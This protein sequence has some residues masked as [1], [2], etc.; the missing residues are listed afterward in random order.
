[1]KKC[2][3]VLISVFIGW[4]FLAFINDDKPKPE[5][6]PENVQR[7]G[8]AKKGY[9]YLI[10][11][12]YIKSGLP[13]SFFK[14]GLGRNKNNFLKR[15]GINKDISHE[16]TAIKAPNGQMVV[17]PNCL[18]CHAQVFDGELIIGM[19]N[20]AVDFTEQKSIPRRMKNLYRFLSLTTPKKFAASKEFLLSTQTLAPNLVTDVRGVNAAGRLAALLVAHRNPITL[21]WSTE[22][23]MDVPKEVVPTDVPAWWLLKKKNAM[24]Y[25][26][27]GRGDFPKFLM[28]SNLL[29]VKDTVEANEVYSHF[30]DV[31]AYIYSITPPKYPKQINKMLAA[32]G[33]QIFGDNCAKCHGTY[34]EDESYPNLLI[35][36]G[37]IQTDS[38]LFKSNYTAPQFIS[39]FNNSWFTTGS[40][41][42]MLVP[43]SGYIAPPLDGIWA[44]APYL[45][46]GSVP[47]LEGV[48]SSK[49]RPTFWSRNFEKPEYNYDNPGWKVTVYENK[50]HG[51]VYN[52]NKEGYGNYGHY[53]G[54]K[55]SKTERSAVI[56]YLKT[57]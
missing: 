31:L 10:T 35:P 27:F 15:D 12:D 49:E 8:D 52:T 4:I 17:T 28:A 11:G 19:G 18:Q 22:P 40:N 57:L 41:P 13:Y 14:M 9:D 39:W 34:G 25:N 32:N 33:K 45:H 24:F 53:F 37:I 48:L 20:T 6:I 2:V 26:G 47:N 55:L 36:A 43:Y 16:F 51:N 21:Q 38:A 29:T 30:N 5:K 54:D 56:E 42:A 1:M 50:T 44:T 3:T 46:N 7:A 23:I